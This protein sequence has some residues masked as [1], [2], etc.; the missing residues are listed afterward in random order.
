MALDISTQENL[1]SINL[2]TSAGKAYFLNSTAREQSNCRQQ[3]K[4][5]NRLDL[6]WLRRFKR[7]GRPL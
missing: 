1:Y 4:M 6:K 7:A 2:Y 3:H 5:E